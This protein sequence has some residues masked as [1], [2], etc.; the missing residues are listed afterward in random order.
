M[1]SLT[2]C[3][4][5]TKKYS[6]DLQ[7]CLKKNYKIRLYKNKHNNKKCFENNF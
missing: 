5:F 6:K 7:I 1:L 4:Q 3:F 2:M